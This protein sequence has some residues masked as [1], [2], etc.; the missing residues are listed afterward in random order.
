MRVLI[1]P[2]RFILSLLLIGLLANCKLVGSR[3]G[4]PPDLFDAPTTYAV[5]T[6]PTCIA[7]AD[8]NN[9]DELDLIT[10]NMGGNNLS[11]LLGNG[12]GTFQE[13]M[14]TPVG[15]QPRLL[16]VAELTGDQRPDVVVMHSISTLLMILAGKGDGTFQEIQRVN[17]GKTPTSVLAADFNGDKHLDIA[18]SLVLDRILIFSGNGKGFFV[19][20][21]D[22]DPGDTPTGVTTADLNTDGKPD[23]IVANNG[24]IGHNIALFYG[25]GDGTFVPAATYRTPLAPLIV[26]VSDFTGDDILDIVVIY[27][28]RNTL[29]LLPGQKDGTFK[30]PIPFGAEGGP[31]DLVMGDY[32]HDGRLDLAVPNNLS[33]NLSVLLGNGDGTFIQ[34]P[35]DYRTGDVPLS[36]TSGEFEKGHPPGLAVANNGSS[37]VSVFR[38]KQPKTAV[39][40]AP[41]NPEK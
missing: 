39:P 36:V 30:D 6:S 5:G 7:T 32:N 10:C 4:P 40:T 21:Y 24:R 41:P 11:V 9:D 34:P 20:T 38:A 33:H 31:A 22:F 13:P 17:L 16:S 2:V 26:G 37:T 29:A 3:T 8:F 15:P 12:N 18:V 1:F 19:L 28:E 27:G 35:I 25:K 23:L 14:T